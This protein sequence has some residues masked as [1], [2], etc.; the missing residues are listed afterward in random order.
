VEP[1]QFDPLTGVSGLFFVVL[2]AAAVAKKAMIV[3]GSTSLFNIHAP[4][5]S[6]GW[7]ST[8]FRTGDGK[9]K[10][11]IWQVSKN[12]AKPRTAKDAGRKQIDKAAG[13]ARLRALQASE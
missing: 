9:K 11:A 13:H 2:D 10:F 7:P 1:G 6:C 5:N 3:R 8:A 4:C 12:D